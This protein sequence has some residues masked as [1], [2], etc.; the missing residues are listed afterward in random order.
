[1]NWVEWLRIPDFLM[2]DS[3]FDEAFL[4]SMEIFP[5]PAP[6]YF[7]PYLYNYRYQKGICSPN[8]SLPRM[9]SVNVHALVL[10]ASS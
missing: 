8:A 10:S 5:G 6:G 1:M 7:L 3:P 9:S 2:V 4:A